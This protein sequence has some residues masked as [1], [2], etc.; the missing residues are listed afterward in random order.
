VYSCAPG[1]TPASPPTSSVERDTW[2]TTIDEAAR[3]IVAQLDDKSKELVRTTVKEQLITFNFDWGRGIRNGLG[4]W[5]GN[6]KLLESCGRGTKAHPETCSMVIIE[7]VWTLLQRPLAEARTIA[8]RAFATSC[9]RR[10]W[11]DSAI[12]A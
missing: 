8:P 11:G 4:L 2:P 7:A 3:R 10:M 12:L 9:A 5:R 6:E 1:E